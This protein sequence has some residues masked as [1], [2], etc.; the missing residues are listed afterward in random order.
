MHTRDRRSITHIDRILK[1]YP[2]IVL[3]YAIA[4]PWTRSPE[5]RTDDDRCIIRAKKIAYL[6]SPASARL[7]LVD[8]NVGTPLDRKGSR[9]QSA[10]LSRPDNPHARWR[11][12]SKTARCQPMS[13]STW[14]SGVTFIWH[15]M[16]ANVFYPDGAPMGNPEEFWDQVTAPSTHLRTPETK[17]PTRCSGTPGRGICRFTHAGQ[18]PVGSLLSR[19]LVA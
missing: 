9:V 1:R 13:F 10:A 7:R 2:E 5:D 17:K 16:R 3:S 19:R 11:W 18:A 4:H 14:R 8:M 6:L 12:Q 15:M